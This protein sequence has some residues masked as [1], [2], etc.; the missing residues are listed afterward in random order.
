MISRQ[1]EHVDTKG[2]VADAVDTCTRRCDGNDDMYISNE[3]N[4][5]AHHYGHVFRIYRAV[6]NRV[7]VTFLAELSSASE[8]AYTATGDA[9]D[10]DGWWEHVW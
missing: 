4:V 7:H 10:G 6:H 8:C 2:P 3:C 9:T 5:G 1:T